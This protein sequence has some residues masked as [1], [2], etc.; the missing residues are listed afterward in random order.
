[1]KKQ[2]L[3]NGARKRM[4]KIEKKLRTLKVPRRGLIVN[5]DGQIE[6][7]Q[8]KEYLKGRIYELEQ[9]IEHLESKL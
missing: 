4:S 1:M 6:Y 7:I 8:E 2:D 9:L 3:I 5:L